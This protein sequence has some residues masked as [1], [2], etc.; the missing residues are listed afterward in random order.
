MT[1]TGLASR[2]SL[3]RALARAAG[4]TV[5]GVVLASPALPG[6]ALAAQANRVRA[7][8]SETVRI[9]LIA[10]QP[11]WPAAE[12]GT[13]RLLEYAA[14][15]RLDMVVHLGGI[16][17]DTESCGDAL[18][19]ARQRLLD[20]SPLPLVYLPGETD[21]AECQRAV[22]GHFDPVERLNRLRE[23]FYPADTTLGQ[24]VVPLMRQSDQ[25]TFRSFREN[26]RWSA[27][28]VLL[29]ALNLPGDNNHYRS[30]G[31]RNGEFEDRR[32]ANRQWLARAFSL[33]Q[34]QNLPGIV[35][36]AHADPQFGNGWE[37]RGKP[38]LF[39]GFLRRRARDGFQE[40]KRQLR[41]LATRYR[42][43]VLLVH[44]GQGG[45]GIDTPLKD[46]GGKVLRNV[47]RVVLPAGT[48]GQFAELS[49]TPG[50]PK[51]FEVTLKDGPEAE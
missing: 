10:D 47:T 48:P 26:V 14:A 44:T 25:A 35:V 29:V 30:E 15:R 43:Q 17:G 28:G 23:L 39:D 33:A 32:E 18:L 11:Q 2:R 38:S 1:P 12:D 36:L 19:T 45:F 51:P 46:A 16:K 42:G 13:T 8:A 4:C 21:W 31:G 3:A 27:G 5:L 41:D 37:Q 50:S 22:N 9:A 40:Y 34:Q 6:D 7:P 24:R 20:Q 49:I